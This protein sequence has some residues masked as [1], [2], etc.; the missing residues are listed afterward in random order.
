V[1]PI[2]EFGQ[3]QLLPRL[4]NLSDDDDDEYED[5]RTEGTAA[6]GADDAACDINTADESDQWLQ[7]RRRQIQDAEEEEQAGQQHAHGQRAEAHPRRRRPPPLELPSEL[8][9][10]SSPNARAAQRVRED[11]AAATATVGLSQ[12]EEAAAAAA[13][14]AAEEYGQALRAI[15]EE[16]EMDGTSTNF[17]ALE[18][19]LE[20]SLSL[21]LSPAAK[22][23]GDP[24]D[25][26][27]AA[28]AGAGQS[29]TASD[30]TDAA[31]LLCKELAQ[32]QTLVPEE[33]AILEEQGLALAGTEEE[34][35]EGGSDTESPV[36]SPPTEPTTGLSPATHDEEEAVAGDTA[37]GAV[38][39]AAAKGQKDAVEMSLGEDKL[40][41]Y[42]Q[43]E[44]CAAL[45]EAWS[46][47]GAATAASAD[48]N[49]GRSA[50]TTEFC[51]PGTDMTIA[52]LPASALVAS[53]AAAVAAP[54]TAAVA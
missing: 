41:L 15:A 27:T 31:G 34:E 53:N 54:A 25:D 51:P 44:F 10:F 14:A 28:A 40:S 45:L 30:Q 23:A 4:D 20:R 6:T 35:E 12:S 9:T 17:V 19:T 21:S 3:L 46:I 11:R 18:Q 5:L 8:V 32:G 49:K 1:H 39:E 7:E 47:R 48:A 29:D 2:A 38:K 13:A 22:S 36:A 26:S 42:L 43:R 37:G 24:D 50:S 33:A 52:P 16:G